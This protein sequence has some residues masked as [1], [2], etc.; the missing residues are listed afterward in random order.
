MSDH[1]SPNGSPAPSPSDDRRQL[2]Y[3]PDVRWAVRRQH[4]GARRLADMPQAKQEDRMIKM[5]KAQLDTFTEIDAVGGQEHLRNAQAFYKARGLG[6]SRHASRGWQVTGAAST[7]PGSCVFYAMPV[8]LE[9]AC[10]EP[11]STAKRWQNRVDAEV[12]RVS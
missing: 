5:N 8:S 2:M 3:L 1:N 10:D 11:F 6:L 9:A 12:A 7:V 4:N